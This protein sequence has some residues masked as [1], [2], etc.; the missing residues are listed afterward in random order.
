M[1]PFTGA[2]SLRKAQ[3]FKSLVY[4]GLVGFRVEGLGFGASRVGGCAGCK[5]V[6]AGL[7]LSGSLLKTR[8]HT[9]RVYL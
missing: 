5:N 9:E 7:E 3:W 4:I 8:Y 6:L 2:C 1:P